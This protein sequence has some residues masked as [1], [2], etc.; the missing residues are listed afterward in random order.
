MT[1]MTEKL[2]GSKTASAA[3]RDGASLDAPLPNNAC[4]Q[5]GSMMEQKQAPLSYQVHGEDVEVPDVWHL[6]CGRCGEVVFSL[7]QATAWSKAA[8]QRYRHEHGLLS[9]GEIRALREHLGLSQSELAGLLRL[10]MVTIAR[11]ES[12]RQ[13]QTMTLDVLL[14]ML[15]DVPGNLDYLRARAA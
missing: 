10:D 5:C 15:R 7:D 9:A 4:P 14:R 6:A 3:K 8:M 11:W 1:A 12:D 13:T 2:K